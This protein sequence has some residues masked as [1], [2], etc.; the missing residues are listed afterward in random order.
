MN[1]GTRTVPDF[2]DVV[3][4]HEVIAAIEPSRHAVN[5]ALVRRGDARIGFT[6]LSMRHAVDIAEQGFA[7]GVPTP[8]PRTT[9]GDL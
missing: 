9:E 2:A 8:D 6:R 1:N 7:S 4:R 3:R 5:Q